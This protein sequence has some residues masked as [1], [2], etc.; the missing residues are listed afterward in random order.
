MCP[1]E[2]LWCSLQ[3]VFLMQIHNQPTACLLVVCGSDSTLFITRFINLNANWFCEGLSDGGPSLV[4]SHWLYVCICSC[5]CAPAG[6]WSDASW[7]KSLSCL[8]V[9]LKCCT[10][11]EC[12]KHVRC[13]RKKRESSPTTSWEFK[14]LRGGKKSRENVNKG[15]WHAACNNWMDKTEDARA[16]KWSMLCC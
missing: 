7:R 12:C 5:V 9:C 1:F 13:G 16:V 11:I 15:S 14:G 4:F 10:D 6:S 2:Y 3:C 8:S